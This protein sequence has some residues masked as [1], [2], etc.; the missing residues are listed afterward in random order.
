MDSEALAVGLR[1]VAAGL[2]VCAFAL[3]GELVKPKRFAGIFSAAPS[4]A[5]A[6][7]VVLLVSEGS[8]HVQLELEGMV[9]GAV[10]FVGC[11]VLGAVAVRRM[12][13][14]RASLIEVA[15]WVAVAGAAYL[16]LLR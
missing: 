9:L 16:V 14:L 2:L 8:G 6:S 13:A 3:I 15:A 5:L 12:G 10:A 4:V 11:T 7:L 1:V